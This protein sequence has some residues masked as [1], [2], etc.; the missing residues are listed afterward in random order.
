[1]EGFVRDQVGG[2]SSQAGGVG[3]VAFH[4]SGERMRSQEA[5]ERERERQGDIFVS[6]FS[7]VLVG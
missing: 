6:P 7:T 2:S 4:P 1:M 3:R 5:V